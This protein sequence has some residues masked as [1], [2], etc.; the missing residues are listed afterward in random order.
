MRFCAHCEA[1]TRT[2]RRNKLCDHCNKMLCLR[3][4]YQPRAKRFSVP[5]KE[6]VW[7][8]HILHLRRLAEQELPLSGRPVME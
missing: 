1:P 5:S 4:M 3:R 8:N 6:R 7:H 2:R